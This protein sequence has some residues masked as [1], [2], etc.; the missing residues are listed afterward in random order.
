MPE[1]FVVTR[2]EQDTVTGFA[3]IA[4]PAAV[5]PRLVDRDPLARAWREH[6][7]RTPVPRDQRVLFMRRSVAA[8]GPSAAAL[9]LDITRR[10]VEM[11][12]QL[13][14]VYAP[15]VDF[16]DADSSCSLV[17]GYLPL[18]GVPDSVSLDFGPAS[19]DGWLAELGARELHVQAD[20]LKVEGLTRLEAGVLAHLRSRE[21]R[22]VARAELLR[23]VWGYDWDGGSNVVDVVVSALRRKLGDRAD[24]LETVR[25]VGYRLRA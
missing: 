12:P 2:D 23:D 22:P 8:Y 11:R 24:T 14:R 3:I 17:I 18:D 19:V 9:F 16:I 20:D 5:S 4:E 15:A 25:G 10:H 13:R 7:R 6:L 1:A 21:G